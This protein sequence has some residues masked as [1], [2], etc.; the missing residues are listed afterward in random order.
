MERQSEMKPLPPEAYEE[1]WKSDKSIR[2]MSTAILEEW[3]RKIKRAESAWALTDLIESQVDPNKALSVILGIMALDDKE[4]EIDHL[5]AG[6]LEDFLNHSGPS[7]I[8]VIEGLAA[9]NPRFKKV[10]GHVWETAEVDPQVWQRV[11]RIIAPRR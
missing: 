7:Y 3:R 10:L 6:P 8:G 4:E 9:R 1:A 2:A 11:E 5:G